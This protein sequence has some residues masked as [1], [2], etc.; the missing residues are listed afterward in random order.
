MAV[1]IS[2]SSQNF[3]YVE[4]HSDNSYKYVKSSRTGSPSNKC[5]TNTSRG[6]DGEK[7]D[8][9]DRTHHSEKTGK[10]YK[11][12]RLL[13]WKMQF[14]TNQSSSAPLLLFNITASDLLLFF[15]IRIPWAVLVKCV[16]ARLTLYVCIKAWL[17]PNHKLPEWL[18]RKQKV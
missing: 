11:I 3:P 5:N 2:P 16:I 14:Q 13:L 6:T 7:T 1:K 12:F 4:E 8:N 9:T 15:I 18:I 17:A 10:K